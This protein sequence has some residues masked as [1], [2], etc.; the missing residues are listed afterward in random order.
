M[1]TLEKQ[2]AQ[3]I[4][5]TMQAPTAKPEVVQDL[6]AYLKTLSPAPPHLSVGSHQEVV[7]RGKTVFANQNCAR[8]HTPPSYTSAGTYDVGLTDEAGHKTFNPPSLRGISQGGPYFHDGRARTLEEVFVRQRHQLKGDLT[9]QEL[10][11]LIAFLG[12][13]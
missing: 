2:V 13:I 7:H 8:C 5:S 12:T 9:K 1:T 10:L 3:S 11:D 4:T 6:T